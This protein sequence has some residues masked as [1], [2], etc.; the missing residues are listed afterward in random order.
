MCALLWIDNFILALIHLIL[1][2]YWEI[3]SVV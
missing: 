2:C 3:I 1:P